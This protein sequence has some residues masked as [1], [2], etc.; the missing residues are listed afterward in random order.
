MLSTSWSRESQTTLI[1]LL[2]D[3]STRIERVNRGGATPLQPAVRARRPGAVCQLLALGAQA[4]YR[5]RRARRRASPPGR[6]IDGAGGTAGSMEEQREIIGL[7]LQHGAEPTF[8]DAAG[9][10]GR[11][12]TR[13][14]RIAEALDS[15]ARPPARSKGR[16]ARLGTRTQDRRYETW[17]EFSKAVAEVAGRH[18]SGCRRL[19]LESLEELAVP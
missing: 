5:L 14:T 15:G 6:S 19:G 9:S 2:V 18:C 16:P 7:L 12:C 8:A 1:G 11:E 3:H 10:T 4:Q 17:H 13:N